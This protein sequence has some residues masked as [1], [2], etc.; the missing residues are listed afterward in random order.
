MHKECFAESPGA[1]VHPGRWLVVRGQGGWGV[2]HSLRRAHGEPIEG[3]SPIPE[4]FWPHPS[5]RGPCAPLSLASPN[6]ISLP[7]IKRVG[8]SDTRCSVSFCQK[9]SWPDWG[10]LEGQEPR[11]RVPL[12]LQVT[13]R[14][15]SWY[16]SSQR[17][18]PLAM[19]SCID[20]VDGF[21]CDHDV[22]L[23]QLVMLQSLH[24]VGLCQG[25]LHRHAPGFI[26]LHGHLG[27]LVVGGCSRTGSRKGGQ[28]PLLFPSQAPKTWLPDLPPPASLSCPS[29][30]LEKE[31]ETCALPSGRCGLEGWSTTS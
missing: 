23:H 25:G 10:H 9:S 14:R 20:D 5:P 21:C 12:T 31:G 26:V 2:S 1:L 22:Q 4:G 3:S 29:Q 27:V 13:R 19:N 7:L 8:Q 11:I 24:Q 16:P 6:M 17:A 30:P 15:H 28:G 18:A